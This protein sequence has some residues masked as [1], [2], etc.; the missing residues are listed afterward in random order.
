MKRLKLLILAVILPLLQL[1]AQ[2][3][4]PEMAEKLKSV[5]AMFDKNQQTLKDELAELEE[6]NQAL[7]KA[8]LGLYQELQAAEKQIQTLSAENETLKAQ[9]TT[10]SVD[11][12]ASSPIQTTQVAAAQ[13]PEEQIVNQPSDLEPS[14]TPQKGLINLNTASKEELMTLPLID[15]TMAERIISNRPYQQVEDL[16]INHEFGPMK[17][18][19]VSPHVTIN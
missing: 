3:T 4:D 2:T 14:T 10:L 11:S 5:M 16:I 1:D 9:L 12:F 6:T 15:E 8:N 18:R 17:L 19:R 13:E 7:T